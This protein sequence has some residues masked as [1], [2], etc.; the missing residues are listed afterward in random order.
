MDPFARPMPYPTVQDDGRTVTL[1]LHGATVDEALTLTVR[2][3]H[4]SEHRGRSTL[5]LI[6]GHSTSAG[7]RRT[8][9]QA[10]H[11]ALDAGEL[12]HYQGR[13]FRARGHVLLSLDPTAA[14]D[15][16]RIRMTD[17]AP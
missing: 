13:A 15:A 11:D 16:H 8:I 3:L 12:A 6:H 5:K 10:L 7:R 4:E 9:K 2:A 14:P 1:D 17:L